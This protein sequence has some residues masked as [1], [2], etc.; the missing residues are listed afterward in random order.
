MKIRKKKFKIILEHDGNYIFGPP[1]LSVYMVLALT[2]N[3][4]GLGELDK[5]TWQCD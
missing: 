1:P 3:V 4:P 5:V 2:S